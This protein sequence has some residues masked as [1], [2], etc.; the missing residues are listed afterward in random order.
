MQRRTTPALCCR[1][2]TGHL[3]LSSVPP[4]RPL[5]PGSH[6]VSLPPSDP[7]LRGGGA[8]D[9]VTQTLLK[10]DPEAH[11]QGKTGRDG[12]WDRPRFQASAGC[13]DRVPRG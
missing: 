4:L 5:L 9:H 7:L 11:A 3:P 1:G 6:S 12:L 10:D 8:W 2:R 13:L